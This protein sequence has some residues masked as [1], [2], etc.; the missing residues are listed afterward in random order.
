MEHDIDN[1]VLYG[2][3]VVGETMI[4]MDGEDVRIDSLFIGMTITSYAGKEYVHPEKNVWACNIS[5][6]AIEL[7]KI[8]YAVR[9]MTTKRI[10]RIWKTSNQWVEVTQDHSL[11]IVGGGDLLQKSPTDI[12]PTDRLLSRSGNEFIPLLIEDRG[13]I[14][15]YVYDIEVAY[16][17]TFFG[18]GILVHNTD[19]AY[20]DIQ[21]YMETH[22]IEL[23]DDNAV[24]VADAL[25]RE[26][27]R[28][29]PM[30]LSDKFLSPTK[31]IQRLEAGREGVFKG[32]IF[33]DKLLK[34]ERIGVK[35]RYAL[36]QIDDEGKRL[37]KDE[38]GEGKMKIMGMETRRSDTPVFIQDFLLELLKRV[39][40]RSETY[41][42]VYEYV[43]AFRKEYH[44]R[45]L[46]QNGAPSG[47]SNVTTGAQELQDHLDRLASG[48][49][50]KM[51]YIY[52]VTKACIFTNMLMDEY[53]ENRWGHISDGDKVQTLKL[54]TPINGFNAVAIKSDE[55][56]IPEWFKTLPFDGMTM[57][58]TLDKKIDNVI[59]VTG[60]N[61]VPRNNHSDDITTQM[62]DFY[63]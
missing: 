28:D 4:A 12:L 55:T 3:S 41:E 54:S 19:S 14:T 9:H 17:H 35:K 50:S 32:G 61:L 37:R 8:V 18:N 38:S 15:D 6:K 7:R 11:M 22:D 51:P 24:M 16:D 63:D 2:D 57:E 45:S 44:M 39:I 1:P 31:Y 43:Q 52:H 25:E 58:A 20:C 48:Q 47:V 49:V 46:W 13:Y 5:N 56:Y 29:I 30:I 40:I 26:L 34:G 36:H 21:K 60:W 23:T 59:G 10:Y 62:D 27:F 33:K 53:G 42:Q